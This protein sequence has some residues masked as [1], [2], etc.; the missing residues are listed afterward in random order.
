MRLTITGAELKKGDVIL[1]P[2]GKKSVEERRPVY[3][4]TSDPKIKPG[5]WSL[6]V[7]C[8]VV[9]RR[10]IVTVSMGPTEVVE[11]ERGEK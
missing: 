5:T 8:S 10:Q 11:V 3:R 9:G 4:V 7:P 2:A 6:S 1:H